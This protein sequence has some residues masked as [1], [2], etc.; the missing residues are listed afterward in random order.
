MCGKRMA[1]RIFSI[2][3]FIY[4]LFPSGGLLA[5]K[6][7]AADVVAQTHR[8]YDKVFDYQCIY[9]T[10]NVNGEGIDKHTVRY[11]FKKAS[12][13]RIELLE[14]VVKGF[15]AFYRDGEIRLKPRGF[16]FLKRMFLPPRKMFLP[17]GDAYTFDPG[18]R[19]VRSPG[20]GYRIDESGIDNLIDRADSWVRKGE[21][22]LTKKELVFE[23]E[24]YL[25]E[26]IPTTL[27]GKNPITRE[28]LWVDVET[29]LPLQYEVYEA[30]DRMV[31]SR[32]FKDLKV[33]IGLSDKLFRP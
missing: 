4:L 32:A 31:H 7:S 28:R 22:V 19:L 25:I 33:N 11:F 16:L 3:L 30:G 26:A 9:I 24:C 8:S 17:F 15:V 6:L 14:G 21:A 10:S 18:D 13:I 20:R 2:I 27:V 12:L 29:N 23:S 5:G 1:I